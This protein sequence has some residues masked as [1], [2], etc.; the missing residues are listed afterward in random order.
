LPVPPLAATDI[1]SVDNSSPVIGWVMESS[2]SAPPR[3]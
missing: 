3:L 1:M 2:G